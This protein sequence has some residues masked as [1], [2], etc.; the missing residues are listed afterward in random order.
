[1]DDGQS[2]RSLV[3]S[4]R[5]VSPAG[6]DVDG[7]EHKAAVTGLLPLVST[8]DVG[9]AL[10]S[11]RLR[12]QAMAGHGGRPAVTAA[13]FA[14]VSGGVS[15][16]AS[17]SARARH[18]PPTQK[19][20]S[21]VSLASTATAGSKRSGGSGPSTVASTTSAAR[22]GHASST[23]VNRRRDPAA[24]GVSMGAA[25]QTSQ[26][27][28]GADASLDLPVFAPPSG[29]LSAERVEALGSSPIVP[30]FLAMVDQ[31][32]SAPSTPGRLDLS[33]LATAVS[34]SDENDDEGASDSDSSLELEMKRGGR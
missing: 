9:G 11:A 21:V 26:P 33:A 15:T 25:G 27:A 23:G 1:M 17:E 18:R 19:S 8:P 13:P 16:L 22:L 12:S 28:D 6:V 5:S 20:G 30:S 34:D 7:L 2:I 14:A 3:D 32:L 10:G 31:A 24:S 4:G 29:M